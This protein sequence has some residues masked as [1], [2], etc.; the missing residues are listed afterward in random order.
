MTIEQGRVKLQVSVGWRIKVTLG[1][2]VFQPTK[3]QK[4]MTKF[5]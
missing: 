5:R 1:A 2:V 3:S 4:R